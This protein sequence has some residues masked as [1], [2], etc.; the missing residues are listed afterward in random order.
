M[1]GYSLGM[2]QRLGLAAALVHDPE[3]LFLDEPTNGLD[4]AGILEMRGLLRG[5]ADQG[6]TIFLSSH[7]LHE[8]E[9]VCSDVVILHQGTVRLQ[10]AVAELLANTDAWRLRVSPVERA[11]ALAED[12]GITAEATPDGDLQVS[13]PESDVPRLVRLLA[14]AGVDVYRVAEQG[15]NLEELFLQ[16]TAEAEAS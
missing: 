3:L 8:V 12:A 14:G 10:G 1:G 4:P 6:K 16:W 5:L 15:G 11:V 7:I 2:R 13:L 9:A